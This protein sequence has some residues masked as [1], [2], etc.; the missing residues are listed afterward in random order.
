MSI[1]MLIYRCIYICAFCMI[2]INTDDND[3]HFNELL[4]TPL[5][6]ILVSLSSFSYLLVL[7]NIQ[8]D[9]NAR[10]TESILLMD[11][12]NIDAYHSIERNAYYTYTYTYTYIYVYTYTYIYLYIYIYIYIYIERKAYFIWIRHSATQLQYSTASLKRIV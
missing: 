10:V 11:Q 12:Q 8:I 9:Y 3:V 4:K 1:Y 7:R 6:L 5:L 2:S